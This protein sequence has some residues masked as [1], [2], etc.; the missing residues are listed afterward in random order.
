MLLLAGG[1]L[2][3]DVAML[4]SVLNRRRAAVAV[5]A[6]LVSAAALTLPSTPAGAISNPVT[7]IVIDSVVG[8][9]APSGTALS[10]PSVLTAKD[11]TITVSV[12]FLD[13][14]DAAASFGKAT[15]VKLTV[16]GGVG[17]TS[18]TTVG[19]TDTGAT[20]DSSA[21]TA[22]ANNVKVTVSVPGLKGKSA[23]PA[24]TYATPFD[25]L[26]SLNT[27]PTTTNFVRQVTKTGGSACPEVTD[28]NPYCATVILPQGAGPK[29]TPEVMR[30][31]VLATGLCDGQAYTGDCPTNS[32]VVELLADLSRYSTTAPATVIL[33]CDKKFCG[34]G[35]IKANVPKF[36]I[37]GNDN[38]VDVPACT[39]KGVAP[40][41]GACVDYVQSTRDNAGDTHL[42][43]LFALDARFSCC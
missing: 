22:P 1:L 4:N 20:L 42:W 29:D 40:A 39:A 36:V 25:V 26:S 27:V 16:S 17:G 41:T 13:S 24:V 38:L 43:V 2:P 15:D 11:H 23:V 10:Q 12:R 35:A 3:K 37:G 33:D 34:H 14:T 19:A 6:A 32:Y 21:F 9:T 31:I 7:H 5:G 28:T 18:V 8:E 30:D